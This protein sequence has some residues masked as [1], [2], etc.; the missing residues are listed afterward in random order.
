PSPIHTIIV[1]DRA[2]HV[3]AFDVFAAICRRLG[4]LDDSK[5]TVLL[6]ALPSGIRSL[7]IST[8]SWRP[9]NNFRWNDNLNRFTSLRQLRL[10]GCG[11]PSLSR[12]RLPSLELLD[13]SGNNIDHATMAN[14]AGFPA[15]KVL[16]L[17]NNRLSVLPTGVFAYLKK[18]TS[19]S[20]ANNS[21][22]EA[23][24][25]IL[26]GL[27][28]L[29]AL[30]LDRNRIPVAHLNDLI[31]DVPTLE[32]LGLGGCHVNPL[33]NLTLDRLP[34]LRTLDI[35]GNNLKRIPS[36]ELSNLP[37]LTSL[38]LARNRLEE[39]E[40]CAFCGNNLTKLDLSHNKLGLRGKPLVEGAF[41]GTT[42][43]HL[44][45]GFNHIE[46]FDSTTIGV[47]Q[48]TLKTLSLSGNFLRTFDSKATRTLHALTALHL[49][50]NMITELPL[51]F[52]PEY[53]QLKVLNLSSNQLAYLPDNLGSLLGNLKEF[54]LSHNRISS[55]ST[56]AAEFIDTIDQVYL[57]GNP[58]DCNCGLTQ[59]QQHMR[60]RFALRRQLDYGATRCAAPSILKAQPVL[61][62][63][64]VNDC[65]VLFGARR[66][67]GLSQSGEL[68]VLLG[69]L[70]IAGALL[71]IL[72]L[73]LYY[74][75]ERQYKGSYVTRE[76]SR[77]P[78][79]MTLPPHG[80]TGISCSTSSSSTS[81]PTEDNSF[82]PPLPPPPPKAMSALYFGV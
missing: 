48:R 1:P 11:M 5:L 47:A 22:T 63:V 17:S 55:L 74:G 49:A 35:S 2:D 29:R 56:A 75:R 18:L 46:D 38:S 66:V 9:A 73:L 25:N 26:R 13:V 65:A 36:I 32:E 53:Y 52:P 28:N 12:P 82:S 4:G 61:S 78:L 54:D 58:W 64:A 60:Q 62:A 69:A 6:H 51:L 79:T 33:Q 34:E 72:L 71:V 20:L 16:D 21:I 44:D 24:S 15:L 70:L 8:P 59:L 27:T 7:E 57:A 37:R 14:F 80:I 68:M 50:H 30:R 67:Y 81:D 39:I 76:C 40:P 45:L 19:L 31:S 42:L 10:I 41:D 43:T 23:S 77:T 3:A